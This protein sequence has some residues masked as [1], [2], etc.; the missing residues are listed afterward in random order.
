MAATFVLFQPLALGGGERLAV[1]VGGVWSILIVTEA[2]F[3]MPAPLVAEQVTLVGG[4]SAV[5]DILSQPDVEA[6]PVSGSLTFQLTVT[7]P[8]YQ[9]AL[10]TLPAI[11]GRS[12][13]RS[14]PLILLALC[15]VVS[16]PRVE[17][18]QSVRRL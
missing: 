16:E 8:M 4:V 2:E 3:D 12:R 5:N 13:A 1:P 17:P 9:L 10:P 11:W 15:Q 6:I 7:G 18:R 14:R